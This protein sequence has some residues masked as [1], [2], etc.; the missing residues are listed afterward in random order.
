MQTPSKARKT[1]DLENT[2]DGCAHHG[3][4]ARVNLLE[5]WMPQSYRYLALTALLTHTKT[6]IEQTVVLIKSHLEAI[7]PAATICGYTQVDATQ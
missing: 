2:G 1:L 4:R 6:T 5:R 3:M 7:R